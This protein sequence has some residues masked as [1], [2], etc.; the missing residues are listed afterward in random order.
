MS[1]NL[2]KWVET[3]Y[4]RIVSSIAF[5]PALIALAFLTVSILMIE[6]DFSEYGKNL[7]SRWQ[8]AS[9]KDAD[10]A[11]T[12]VA[13]IGAGILSLAVFS[14]SMVMILLNQ[15]ASNMSNR[16]L[17]SMIGNRFHQSILG[18]YIGTIVYSFFLLSTIRDIDSG[19]YVP[20]LSVY[21]LIGLT[22]VDIFL[23]IYFLHYIT[24][25]VKYETIIHRIHNKT[26]NALK[27]TCLLKSY[28]ED[29]EFM[30]EQLILRNEYSGL[31]QRIDENMLLKICEKENIRIKLLHPTGSFILQHIPLMYIFGNKG[32]TTKL[33]DEIKLGVTIDR[34]DTPEDNYYYGFRQLMEVAVKAVSPGINDPGTAILSLRS[35]ADLLIYRMQFHPDPY[36]KDDKGTIRILKKERTFEEL[37]NI[38]ILPVWDYARHDRLVMQELYDLL[39]Q[40]KEQ[41]F[42]NFNC[43]NQ[44]AQKV[45]SNIQAI[46]DHR[47]NG[48]D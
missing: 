44:L 25:S 29:I 21:L 31:F 9:L 37:F 42:G 22:I 3:H 2:M 15:A 4:R 34:S 46:E 18:F 47:F 45:L 19:I 41:P 48:N 35:I 5:Y 36:V 40:L 11:R 13:T 30:G 14:F 12:I 16:V 20:A 28:Q 6:L 23:F 32:D 24:Q 10:T 1:H 39:Q 17:D 43:I 27:K 38:C 26:K 8:W 33:L 7:K